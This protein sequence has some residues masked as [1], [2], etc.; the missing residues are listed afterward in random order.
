MPLA[1]DELAEIQSVKTGTRRVA[2]GEL[3]LHHEMGGE[4]SMTLFSGWAM[5][6]VSRVS[7]AASW[8]SKAT[9]PDTN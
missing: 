1:A 2:A 5:R 8:I 6:N 7:S 4:E 3:I 9:E